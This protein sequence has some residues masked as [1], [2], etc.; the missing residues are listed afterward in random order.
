MLEYAVFLHPI[1]NPSETVGGEVKN[2]REEEW[3]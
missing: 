2:M 1:T 3:S